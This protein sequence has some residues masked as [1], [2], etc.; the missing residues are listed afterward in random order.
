MAKKAYSKAEDD[1]I[2]EIGDSNDKV[3]RSGDTMTGVLR[4]KDDLKIFGQFY[5]NAPDLETNTNMYWQDADEHAIFRMRGGKPGSTTQFSALDG[6]A[7]LTTL[8]F[9]LDGTVSLYGG[10]NVPLLAD[11]I[12]RKD[13]VDGIADTKVDKSDGVHGIV[14]AITSLTAK[15]FADIIPDPNIMYVVPGEEEEAGAIND[16]F[17]ENTQNIADNYIVAADRNAMTTGPIEIDDTITVTVEDGGI[18]TII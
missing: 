2:F 13:Y 3:A 9:N 17:Y 7:T 18:W 6:G 5:M 4:I 1:T 15:E 11:N 10:G 14:N 16:L 12:T 8:A